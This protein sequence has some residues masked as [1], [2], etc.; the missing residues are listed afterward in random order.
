MLQYFFTYTSLLQTLQVL[1][2]SQEKP[3]LDV[4]SNVNWMF[5]KMA[6]KA[7]S[8]LSHIRYTSLNSIERPPAVTQLCTVEKLVLCQTIAECPL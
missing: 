1:T 7:F 4:A 2:A 6:D 3:K 5:S 8:G